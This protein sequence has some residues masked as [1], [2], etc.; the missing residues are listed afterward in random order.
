[1]EIWIQTNILEESLLP[2]MEE[3]LTSG[4]D[5]V[6]QKDGAA[7]HTSKKAIKWM[8]ENNFEMGF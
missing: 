4:L 1:M 8:E 6:F 5:F 3:C 2:V 7:C